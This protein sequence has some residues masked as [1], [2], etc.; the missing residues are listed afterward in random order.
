MVGKHE[1]VRLGR[2]KSGEDLVRSSDFARSRGR[3]AAALSGGAALGKI[4]QVGQQRGF[5]GDLDDVKVDEDKGQGDGGDVGARGDG[6]AQQR[7]V[8]VDRDERVDHGTGG[9]DGDGQP[10]PDSR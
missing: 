9:H 3:V 2:R 10:A 5:P 6:D 4:L 8:I 1:S 7:H